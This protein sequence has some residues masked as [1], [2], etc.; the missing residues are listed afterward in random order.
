MK[1]LYLL[2]C[3]ALA[4]LSLLA[5]TGCECGESIS[6]SIHTDL[7]ILE[8]PKGGE[9]VNTL[10]FTYSLRIWT[11]ATMN[12]NGIFFEMGY[13][14]DPPPGVYILTRWVN[15][16]GGEYNKFEKTI[17]LP[18]DGKLDVTL[19]FTTTM[20]APAGLFLDKT[21]WVQY[22]MSPGWSAESEH[23]VCTVK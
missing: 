8:Q 21:F 19:T 6:A 9:N 23:A 12:E 10:T 14:K 7:R 4:I 11:D 22:D 5:V 18:V 17:Y 3:S 13:A 15:N 1:K 20:S 2:L 16:Q